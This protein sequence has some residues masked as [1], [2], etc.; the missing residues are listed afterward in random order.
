MDSFIKN[1]LLRVTT[2]SIEF[3]KSYLQKI[4]WALFHLNCR[5]GLSQRFCDKGVLKLSIEFKRKQR[6]W[7]PFLGNLQTYVY[8]FAKEGTLYLVFSNF[9]W[10]FFHRAP[11]SGCFRKCLQNKMVWDTNDEKKAMWRFVYCQHWSGFL[12]LVFQ[13]LNKFSKMSLCLYW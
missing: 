9:L 13:I 2:I 8:S 4:S 3:R 6:L 11:T 7:S 5:T 12:S 1:N 10:E